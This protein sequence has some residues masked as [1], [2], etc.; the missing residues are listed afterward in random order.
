M[1]QIYFA[2][3]RQRAQVVPLIIRL[4]YTLGELSKLIP[5]RRQHIAW[6]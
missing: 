1:K 3:T 5:P 2:K 6:G 4:R